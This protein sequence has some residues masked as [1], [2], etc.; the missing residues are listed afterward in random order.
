[1]GAL[2]ILLIIL[3]HSLNIFKKQK[4]KEGKMT[5]GQRTDSFVPGKFYCILTGKKNFDRLSMTIVIRN[6]FPE[7]LEDLSV[8]DD[9]LQDLPTKGLEC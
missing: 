2:A 1:M 7:T 6:L 4:N 9:I 3:Y 8:F 5:P